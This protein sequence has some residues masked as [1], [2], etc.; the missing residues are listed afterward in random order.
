MLPRR[1]IGRGSRRSATPAAA[2]S[3]RGRTPQAQGQLQGMAEELVEAQ[4]IRRRACNLPAGRRLAPAGCTREYRGNSQ[5]GNKICHIAIRSS[6]TFPT[7][8]TSVR[9]TRPRRASAR[10]SS[11]AGMRDVLKLQIEVDDDVQTS[12]PSSDVRLRKRHPAP[13]AWRQSGSRRNRGHS[14][15]TQEH[16]HRDTN[17]RCAGENPCSV[18][19]EDAISGIQDWKRKNG[20]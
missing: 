15:R 4:S 12:P 1:T 8:G 9:W 18:L 19:A 3:V 14:R 5:R 10:A 17:C 7:R 16:R 13:A 20:K 11:G 2:R 6:I